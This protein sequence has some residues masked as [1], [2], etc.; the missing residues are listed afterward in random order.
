MEGLE[1][2]ASKEAGGRGAGEEC[3]ELQTMIDGKN[4]VWPK[5]EEF[6][7]SHRVYDKVPRWEDEQKRVREPL[8]PA[9][10]R[11]PCRHQ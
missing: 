9:I 6:F 2:L 5:G 1:N 8:P 10:P 4:W 7:F 11:A 3:R